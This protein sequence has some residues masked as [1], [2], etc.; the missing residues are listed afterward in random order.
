MAWLKIY[1]EGSEAADD[2]FAILLY[3]Y[4]DLVKNVVVRLPSKNGSMYS[5]E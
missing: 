4:A 2:I 3:V 5:S 1:V